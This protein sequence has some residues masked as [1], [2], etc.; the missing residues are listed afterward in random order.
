MIAEDE[1][2]YEDECDRMQCPLM[3]LVLVVVLVLGNLIKIV[4]IFR[5]RLSNHDHNKSSG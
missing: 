3:A 5:F 4:R 2:Q 1:D